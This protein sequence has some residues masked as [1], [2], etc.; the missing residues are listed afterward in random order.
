MPSTG[1]AATQATLSAD[2]DARRPSRLRL[3][4]QMEE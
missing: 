1:E 4:G 2:W 3:Q